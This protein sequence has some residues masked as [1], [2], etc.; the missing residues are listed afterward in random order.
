MSSH[1]ICRT[2]DT[3]AVFSY[4][5][6]KLYLDSLTLNG[7]ERALSAPIALPKSYV[8]AQDE[9][10]DFVWTLATEEARENGFRL[11]L[12]DE[13]TE[14]TYYLEVKGRADLCGPIEISG[15]IR[16]PSAS[17]VRILPGEI[18][19]ACLAFPAAPTAWTFM[20]ES[21][22]AENVR[23]HQSPDTF[24]PGTGIYKDPLLPGTTVCAETTTQ[25]DFNS[26]GKIPMI[27]LDGGDA[28]AY[29][30]FEWTSSRIFAASVD[31]GV[32]VSIDLRADFS[33]RIPSGGDFLIPPIYLGVYSGDVDDGSNVFKRWF[34]S[35][36]TPAVM[37]MDENE[38]LAQMDYQLHPK[39]VQKLGIQS[40][41]WDYGWWAE[42]GGA[43]GEWTIHEGS[44]HLRR[45]YLLDRV[46]DMGIT[47]L[48][49]Y[50][51]YLKEL[52]LNWTV[53]VLLH[54]SRTEFEGDE[55]LTSV[56]PTAHPEWF[57]NRLIGGHCPVADLGNEDCVAYCKRKL[58][59]FFTKN[60]IRSW[61]SDFEPIAYISDKENRHDANGTDVQ[62]WCSR[63]FYDIVD[64][65]IDTIPGFRYESC[66]SGGSMK[67]YATL[68]RTPVFNNDDSA[69]WMSL[70][71]TFYDS[72]YCFPPAQLQSPINPDTFCPEC[73]KHYAG[74]GDKHMGMRAAIMGG[75]MLATWS[76]PDGDSLRFDL[77]SYYEEYINLHNQKI[78]PLIRH[79]NLYHTL[80]RPDHIHWDGMQYGTDETP[81]N[82]IGGALFLFKPTSQNE[83]AITV[84]IRGLNPD[85]TYRADFYE[86]GE[87][88]FTATGKELMEKGLTCVI[89]QDCGS[90]IVFFEIV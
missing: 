55:L 85:L 57:S 73:E 2:K 4:R 78:K 53:Y 80:P 49:E 61:R 31:G 89:E 79:A 37:R 43:G 13:K 11:L 17:T 48:A 76:G 60:N 20:K 88:S 47:T 90:E 7:V 10:K 3:A 6:D 71:T 29:I 42:T 33:T 69:D 67:D 40:I 62:Y 83:N 70:R 35:E 21:G 84:S 26:G 32:R 87:Q 46:S 65:L 24:F 50:G 51:S 77:E 45:P 9:T 25:Q 28:G 14:F 68:R 34:F 44:W 12:K 81:E 36:K 74:L 59:A 27:Y 52:G 16:N 23:W 63:G 64:H 72:S 15:C 19:S 56:G 22:V 82:K 66:S 54:D 5:E 1:L 38:P 8:S 86:R 75:V 39:K 30:A 41:K 18:F 58:H